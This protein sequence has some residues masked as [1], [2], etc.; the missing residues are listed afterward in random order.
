MVRSGCLQSILLLAF[1][2]GMFNW[3]E[4]WE[5]PRTQSRDCI[6]L[7]A[8]ELFGI[9]ENDLESGWMNVWICNEL[10]TCPG[11]TLPLT[12]KPLEIGTSS[13]LDPV[14]TKRDIEKGWTDGMYGSK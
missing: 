3:A 2:R 13:P 4:A 11:C 8:W 10:A 1:S 6:S 9:S 14:L 7:L 12:R 5:R